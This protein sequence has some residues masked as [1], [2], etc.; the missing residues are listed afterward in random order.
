MLLLPFS[1]VRCDNLTKHFHRIVQIHGFPK[2]QVLVKDIPKGLSVIS[3]QCIMQQ[4]EFLTAFIDK[5][6]QHFLMVVLSGKKQG[7]V[8]LPGPFFCRSDDS[9]YACGQAVD[10]NGLRMQ[11][12]NPH[13]R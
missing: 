8:R 7:Q 10:G 3:T 1:G 13:E 9:G 12:A 5:D 2:R 6:P 11:P 4:G